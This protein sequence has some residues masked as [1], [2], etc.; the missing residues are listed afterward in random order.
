MNI[1]ISYY[2]KAESRYLAIN[3]GNGT[4]AE[5]PAKKIEADI[6]G[7]PTEKF[8]TSKDGKYDYLCAFHYTLRDDMERKIR[9]KFFIRNND[10]NDI[11][12]MFTEWDR[13]NFQPNN[14]FFLKENLFFTIASFTET[15]EN[16][17]FIC[18]ISES[19]TGKNAVELWRT[20]AYPYSFQM[21]PEQTRLAYH[22]AGYD[23]EF[24]PK[25]H[26][27]INIMELDG[28]RHLVC[29]ETGHLFFGPKWSPNGKWLVFQDCI[30]A[31]DPAH[32][33]SDIAIC[34]P[35]G[36]NFKRLTSGQN[37]YFATSFGLENYRMGGSNFP[38]WTADS[39]LIYSPMLPNSHPDCHFDGT[40]RNHEELIFDSSMGRGGCGFSILDPET[41]KSSVLTPAV[42]GCWDF[43][44]C[45]SKDNKWML[46]T[47]SEFGKAGEIRLR[48]M[49]NGDTH[50][51]TNGT[52]GLGAD[53][54]AFIY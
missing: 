36:T 50:I 54:A 3:H 23:K 47:H 16:A 19:I 17:A 38:I 13:S 14:Y 24:N 40:Q 26:Y 18:D 7:I 34:A 51:I 5:A 42:E 35:D 49:G 9:R 27:S 11:T 33:F 2:D 22:L 15:G 10:T 48:N 44:P 12:E 1:N 29:S 37:C 52:Q 41:G 39:K 4:A 30:P 25:G 43:R 31:D 20:T 46:Y 53:H 45:L 28:T 21:N 6:D 8:A 32:H